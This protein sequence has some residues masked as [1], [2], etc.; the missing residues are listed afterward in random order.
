MPSS[1]KSSQIALPFILSVVM[2]V[3]GLNTHTGS[4]ISSWPLW[5]QAFCIALCYLCVIIKLESLNLSPRSQLTLSFGLGILIA[6]GWIFI[7]HITAIYLIGFV[8]LC[9]LCVIKIANPGAPDN[10]VKTLAIPGILVALSLLVAPITVSRIEINLASLPVPGKFLLHSDP[11]AHINHKASRG[12]PLHDLSAVTV[13]L[14]AKNPQLGEPMPWLE[15]QTRR[16]TRFTITGIRYKF[17]NLD[18]Y[19]MVGSDLH[20]I[21]LSDKSDDVTLEKVESG[22]N[23]NDI[24]SNESAWIKLPNLDTYQPALFTSLKVMVARTGLWILVCL[25]FLA[26]FPAP[27]SRKAVSPGKNGPSFLAWPIWIW[28]VHGLFVGVL[29]LYMFTP[30]KPDWFKMSFSAMSLGHEENY[31]VWWSG[32]CLLIASTL[33]YRVASSCQSVTSSLKWYVLSVALLALGYDEIGSLHE[34]VSKVGDWPALLPFALIFMIGFGYAL[35]GLFRMPGYRIPAI[36]ILLGLGLFASVASLEFVEH[37][38]K[39]TWHQQRNRLIFE[40]GTELFAMS[41]II[42][43]GLLSLKQVTVSDRRLSEIFNPGNLHGHVYGV[44]FLFAIQFTAISLFA[45]PHAGN[46]SEGNPAAVFPVFMFFTLFLTCI[47]IARTHGDTLIWRG[48]AAVF[49]FTSLCQIHSF[50]KLLHRLEYFV[51]PFTHAPDTWIITLA[52]LALVGSALL[53]RKKLATRAA[54]I[55]SALFLAAVAILYPDNDLPMNYHLFSGAVAY[56]CYRWLMLSGLTQR[57]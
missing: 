37:N 17:L 31:A 9:S 6:L 36:L 5:I 21:E 34:M 57:T 28:L 47:Y 48:F 25:V 22:I 15:F 41:L 54:L 19:G 43:A 23:I 51:E 7:N 26:W 49:L 18:I 40:E 33:F 1:S 55:D 56:L 12:Y 2:L 13:Q 27:T 42:I 38:I 30:F 4:F 20:V 35:S 11:E 44:F 8:I 29:Y 46:F 3:S 16:D 24:G 53:W 50:T 45:L 39:M 52:P 14:G 10:P 32:I